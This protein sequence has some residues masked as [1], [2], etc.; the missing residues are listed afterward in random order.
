MDQCP[1]NSKY[2]ELRHS[3]SDSLPD[4]VAEVVDRYS[5]GSK[6]ISTNATVQI[7]RE[8]MKII[9]L[10]YVKELRSD[11]NW[12]PFQINLEDLFAFSNFIL[13]VT[14]LLL[15]RLG[16]K[17]I[18]RIPVLQQ[19]MYL[20]TLGNQESVKNIDMF[21]PN[22]IEPRP[23][24]GKH[25]KYQPENPR[26]AELQDDEKDTCRFNPLPI[27]SPN[28]SKCTGSCMNENENCLYIRD[29]LCRC[30]HSDV[31]S[32]LQESLRHTRE[33]RG[34]ATDEEIVA[35]HL[36][37]REAKKKIRRAQAVLREGEEILKKDLVALVPCE[38]PEDVTPKLNQS[39]ESAADIDQC[40]KK[41]A[42]NDI[43]EDEPECPICREPA[44]ASD[45]P[46]SF[47]CTHPNGG[48]PHGETFHET[49]LDNWI[50]Q[51]N[52]CPLCNQ[53]C[54]NVRNSTAMVKRLLF[55]IF[56][57]LIVYY[58]DLMDHDDWMFVGYALYNIGRY[59]ELHR[60]PPM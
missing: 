1:K 7:F 46:L 40:S 60:G 35:L 44:N 14:S 52:I 31:F 53:K 10:Q 16:T 57:G 45:G 12:N 17:C 30:V 26:G 25:R 38:A 49:C 21:L 42:K 15:N 32:E 24:G 54:T 37:A 8:I 50:Q 56:W 9:A 28:L 48:G 34:E 27:F 51:R 13:Q 4:I 33:D 55:F 22:T 6:E 47:S 19:I 2:C 58:L 41:E 11:K 18:D 3:I 20:Y 39:Q 29:R 5:T 59:Y 43:E 23:S 36:D